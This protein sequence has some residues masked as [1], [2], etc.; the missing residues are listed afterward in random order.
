MESSM[1]SGP[2][3]ARLPAQLNSGSLYSP[4]SCLQTILSSF[5]I[6]A[7]QFP[8]VLDWHFSMTQCTNCSLLFPI[9]HLSGFLHWTYQLQNQL[10]K[11]TLVSVPN[12]FTVQF[13]VWGFCEKSHGILCSILANFHS[14]AAAAYHSLN[15]G[16]SLVISGCMQAM[17]PMA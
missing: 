2:T 6:P 10:R 16:F 14:C 17:V 8:T 13:F 3:L 5:P 12:R 9:Y 15:C 7:L 4:H 1:K 11:P